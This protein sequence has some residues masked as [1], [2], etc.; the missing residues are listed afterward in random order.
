MYDH[1]PTT[2][3]MLVGSAGA[4]FT[5]NEVI[6]PP[7]YVEWQ[8]YYFGYVRVSSTNATQIRVQFVHNTDGK[9]LDDFVIA[10][11]APGSAAA[12]KDHWSMPL[13][14]LL[15][16]IALAV[17]LVG[18][19]IVAIYMRSTGRCAKPNSLGSDPYSALAGGDHHAAA[20][21]A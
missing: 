1:P 8:E 2:V 7:E 15:A 16:L 20:A 3:H 6:P 5:I 12:P 19:A 10:K 21:S 14:E 4:G 13:G 9:I 17:V 11:D 18:C